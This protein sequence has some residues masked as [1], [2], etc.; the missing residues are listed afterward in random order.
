VAALTTRG[1]KNQDME[2]VVDWIDRI[3]KDTDNESEIHQ[4]KSE[5]NQFMQSFP[6]YPDWKINS[7]H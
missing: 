3:L 5:I 4:V 7:G 6:L 2:N 1:L